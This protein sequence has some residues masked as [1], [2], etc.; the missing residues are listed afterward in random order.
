MKDTDES[1][2]SYVNGFFSQPFDLSRAPLLRVSSIKS[3]QNRFILAVDMHHIISDGI[4]MEILTQEF[5]RLSEGKELLPL[6]VQYKDFVQWQDRQRS[7]ILEKQEKYWL[8]RFE[9]DIPQSNLPTDY[10]YPST[11]SFEGRRFFFEIPKELT[12]KVRELVKSTAT[13]LHQFLIAVYNILLSRYTGQDDIVIG[14]PITG[15]SHPDVQQVIGMFVNMICLRNRPSHH[16][17]AIQFLAEVKENVLQAHENQDY[18]FDE[19]IARL[20]IQRKSNRNP[21][22][23]AAFSL[24]TPDAPKVDNFNWNVNDLSFDKNAS[25]FDLTLRA[26]ENPETI[27]MVFEYKTC[28]FKP[29]TIEKLS[30]R[31][32]EI[33]EQVAD[34]PTVQLKEITIAHEFTVLK[35]DILDQDENDFRF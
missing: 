22:F 8:S 23:D 15:R 20:G 19:L 5:I 34:A 35:P 17:T 28:L 9:G 29:E 12:F 11:L 24:F 16:K 14:Y 31:Y 18:P 10:P 1:P 2:S 3:D 30:Q 32:I 33:M 27:Y 26:V 6:T 13:T 21:L 7:G 4:S 25:M